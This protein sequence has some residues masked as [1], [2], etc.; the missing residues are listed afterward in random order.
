M[1]ISTY[2]G[3]VGKK[4]ERTRH[5]IAWMLLEHLS[6]YHNLTWSN[7]FKSEWSKTSSPET[8]LL[9]PSTL[10]NNSGE[11]VSAALSFF[12]LKPD[13]LLVIHD[14]LELPFGTVQVKKG[15]GAGGH[16]GLRSIIKL[17]GSS[18]F[19]RF[20]I[21]ISRPPAGYGV[22]SWVLSRFSPDEEALLPDYLKLAAEVLENNLTAPI[23]PGTKTELL[24]LQIRH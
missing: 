4:Y 9:K 12:K 20:R 5:N 22:S 21:G 18:D 8:L 16:N 10:M 19:Y 23:K 17:T 24:N 14:D 15:G 6:F 7:K 13:S 2:L 1:I 3:N 11:S